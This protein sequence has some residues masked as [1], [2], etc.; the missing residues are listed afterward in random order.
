M[1]LK[2]VRKLIQVIS[3]QCADI[4]Y[5]QSR[6]SLH[7]PTYTFNQS[8]AHFWG[9]FGSNPVRLYRTPESKMD[10][11][12][13]LKSLGDRIMTMEKIFEDEQRGRRRKHILCGGAGE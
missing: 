12:R 13:L 3:A 8:Q 6:A 10:A 2:A 1:A 9:S 5:S 7:N 11:D 4:T